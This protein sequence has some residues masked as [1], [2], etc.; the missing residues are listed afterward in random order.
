M[1][2]L[3]AIATLLTAVVAVPEPKNKPTVPS[4]CDANVTQVRLAFAGGYDMNVAWSTPDDRGSP[5]VRYGKNPNALNRVAY[6]SSSTYNSSWTYANKVTLT[7]LHPDTTYYYQPGCERGC[8]GQVNSFVTAPKQ[9]G[10]GKFDEFTVAVF[11]DLG[12]MGELGLST[13]A[14]DGAESTVLAVGERNT[15][16]SLQAAI[17]EYKFA[18]HLGDI[19]YAD[20]WLKEEVQGYL[21][22]DLEDGYDMYNEILNAF[23]DQI[24]NLSSTKPYMVL[25]GN[26]D[27]NCDNGGYKSYNIDICIESQ[28][29]FTA[30]RN[31]WDMPGKAS[32]GVDNMWYSFDYGPVHFVSINTE[33]DA[34]A[35]LK[36]PDQAGGSGGDPGLDSGNFGYPNEQVDWLAADLAKVDRTKTPWIIV[37]GHRPWYVN[38]EDPVITAQDS[39]EDI[40]YQYGADLVLNGHVHNY[41]RNTAVYKNTTD[42]NGLNNPRAPWYIVNGIA[43]HYDGKDT[44]DQDT[45]SPYMVYGQDTTYGWGKL[46]F[47]NSTHLTYQFITSDNNT[48]LDQATLYK[49]H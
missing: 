1:I 19:A 47:H 9:K 4:G 15:I 37:G 48:V 18:W 5:Y 38:A 16:Q 42:P 35:G 31:F 33:T 40:L 46:I 49:E 13:T 2:S 6:G 22:F 32:G 29:N 41:Q 34:K 12:T 43:G 20:Y 8:T 44:I 36:G 11:G 14:G 30:Y 39:F 45:P 23:Y 7:D 28:R 17:D 21:P 24:A 3:A 26:H 10:N 27:S 25:P